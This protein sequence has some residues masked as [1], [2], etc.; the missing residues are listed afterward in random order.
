MTK[1][2]FLRPRAGSPQIVVA[3]PAMPRKAER[4]YV[5]EALGRHQLEADDRGMEVVSVG[6][7]GGGQEDEDTY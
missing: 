2:A 6:S 5:R 1:L 4:S 3:L 7:Q